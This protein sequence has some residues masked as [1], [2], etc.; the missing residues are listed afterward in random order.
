M[1]NSSYTTAQTCTSLQVILWN[2]PDRSCPPL[3]IDTMH[4]LNIFGVAFLP[5]TNSTHIVT[6]AF[7]RMVQLHRLDHTS[8]V[9]TAGRPRSDGEGAPPVAAQAVR[10]HTTTFLNH[11]ESVK[12]RSAAASSSTASKFSPPPPIQTIRCVSVCVLCDSCCCVLIC[13]LRRLCTP[14][15]NVHRPDY[16]PVL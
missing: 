2:Y 6:S 5:C 14:S 15:S 4:D 12:V 1:L 13:P 3:R 11:S 9:P 7:D 8:M 16:L 10:C